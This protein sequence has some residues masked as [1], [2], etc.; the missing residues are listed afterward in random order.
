MK[1]LHKILTSLISLFSILLLSQNLLLAQ[2]NNSFKAMNY[3]DIKTPAFVPNGMIPSKFTCDGENISPCLNWAAVPEGTQSLVLIMDDPDAP[4]GDWVH[5]ILFNIPPETRQLAE[6][7]QVSKK[8][9][10]SMKAGLNSARK[11]D[12][13]GPCPPSGIHHYFFKIYALDIMLNQPEGIS[14]KDL[15]A[16]ME[17]HILSKGEIIGRYQRGK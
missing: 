4:N 10:P 5:F 15:L 2:N 8:P 16:A 6:N 13:H 3:L 1:K 14:K 12:Y 17:G 7:F 9:S 11:L